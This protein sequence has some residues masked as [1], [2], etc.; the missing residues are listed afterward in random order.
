M[1]LH[2]T[3]NHYCDYDGYDYDY[4][5]DLGCPDPQLAVSGLGGSSGRCR[6]RSRG[7]GRGSGRS[8]GRGLFWRVVNCGCN[9]ATRGETAR[10]QV[11]VNPNPKPLAVPP[12]RPHHTGNGEID[13]ACGSPLGIGRSSVKEPALGGGTPPVLGEQTHEQ[14]IARPFQERVCCGSKSESKQQSY[15]SLIPNRIDSKARPPHPFTNR[16]NSCK[17]SREVLPNLR[18]SCKRSSK[19]LPNLRN[20]CKR[21]SKL[22]PNLRNSCKR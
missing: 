18:N 16:M 20:S 9:S 15:I 4:D 3:H 13:V 6:S 19:L 5:Y 22:L 11:G 1:A 21:S 14:K 7:S 17:R 8:R 12:T 10:G 2:Y